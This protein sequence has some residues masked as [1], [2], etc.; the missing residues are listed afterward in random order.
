MSVKSILFRKQIR[1]PVLMIIILL[2]VKKK[3]VPW[4]KSLYSLLSARVCRRTCS[5][6]LAGR[7]FDFWRRLRLGFDLGKERESGSSLAKEGRKSSAE[8]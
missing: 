2:W 1:L 7:A 8:K 3:P 5:E 4:K 6:N